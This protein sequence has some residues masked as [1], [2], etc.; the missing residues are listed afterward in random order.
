MLK[1]DGIK[2]KI[3]NLSN[4]NV[5]YGM[6]AIYMMEQGLNEDDTTLLELTSNTFK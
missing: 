3:N 5:S 2:L 4:F 6:F 1:N